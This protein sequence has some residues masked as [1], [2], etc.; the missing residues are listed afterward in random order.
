VNVQLGW[1]IAS[2]AVTSFVGAIIGAFGYGLAIGRWK[3]RIEAEI[4]S[5]ARSREHL[6]GE[7]TEVNERLD[8]GAEKFEQTIGRLA[9]FGT[10]ATALTGDINELRQVIGRLVTRT[11][12]DRRHAPKGH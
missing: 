5:A 12:C 2:W 6:R 7:L 4:E 1:L 3:G 10:Q 8:H 9:A 11:E